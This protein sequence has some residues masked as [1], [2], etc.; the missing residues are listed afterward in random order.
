ML[1][2][3]AFLPALLIITILSSVAPP[4]S[5]GQ[6]GAGET[7]CREAALT[8][9]VPTR[10]DNPGRLIADLQRRGI[11]LI[12]V[13]IEPRKAAEKGRAETWTHIFVGR[14]RTAEAAGRYGDSLVARGIVDRFLVRAMPGCGDISRPRRVQQDQA[15]TA[16]AETSSIKS[17]PRW[18]LPRSEGSGGSAWDASLNQRI[19]EPPIASIS[20]RR[21]NIVTLAPGLDPALIPRPDPVAM[22]LQELAP[23][24]PGS[25]G[26]L[27]IR[28]DIRAAA[29]RLEWIAGPAD[30]SAIAV[31]SDGK[32]TLN[33]SEVLRLSGAGR[34]RAGA[35]LVVADYIRSN[36]G[37]YLLTQL[38]RATHRY[39]FYVGQRLPTAGGE[40]PLVGAMNLD[41]NFDQRI[42]PL[43]KDGF[44]V[45]N[46]SPPAEFDAMVGI[47]PTAVWFNIPARR[48]LPDGMIVFHE[49]AEALAK[50]EYGLEY[51]PVGLR[52][53][54]HNIAIQREFKLSSQRPE[55]I[56]TAGGNRVFGDEK[57]LLEF[58]AEF[59]ESRGGR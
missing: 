24:K 18:L 6:T 5:R 2:R 27:W 7:D 16:L 26:G 9:D 25:D 56:T 12:G 33:A 42:N 21:R 41:N 19:G 1:A 47:N 58:E 29:F 51:L 48:L 20:R 28:G 17:S 39:C 11:E 38:I 30:A 34:V 22:A 53:G 57:R 36:E 3:H 44:K 54:A 14:F 52:P 46:E 10:S 59:R 37:L 31:R 50:V 32:V 15:Y 23:R 40:V 49:L 45:P 35:N 8:I 4:N 55:L 43:R 13:T